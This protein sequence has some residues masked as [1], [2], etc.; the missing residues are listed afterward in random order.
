V[1]LLRRA[2]LVPGLALALLASATGRAPAAAED[3]GCGTMAIPLREDASVYDLPHTFVRAGTDS[4]WTRSGPLRRGTDYV[5]DR[6]RGQLRLIARVPAGDTLW[7]SAC[8]LLS[9]LPLS[10]QLFHYRA[11]ALAAPDTTRAAGPAFPL[12]PATRRDPRDAPAG[13]SLNV[14]GNKTIAI[15][16]GSSQDAFLRQSLDLAVSGSLAPGVSLTGVLSDRNTPLSEAGSTQDLQSLD[17][18]LVE[19]KTPQGGAALGDVTLSLPQGD[20]ARL[21]RRLQGARGEWSSRGFQGV[22]AAASAQGEYHRIQFFGIEG[23]QGPYALTDRDGNPGIAVV[24]GSEVVTVDGSRMTRGE[25]ADY[26]MDYERGELTFSNR[27]PVSSASRITVEYQFAVNRYRRNLAAADAEWRLGSAR[28]FTRML[29]EGDDRGRP[30]E[31][32]FD[33]TDRLVLELAGDSLTRAIG[34]GV[35]AGGGDY[36]TVRVAAGQVFAFAGPDAGTF[37]V[38]FARVGAGEGDY[39]D[40]A[41]VAG[42]TAYRFVGA[43]RGAYRVG[44]ALPLPES[45]QL[46]AV[47]GGVTLGPLTL[48]TEGAVSRHDLNTF[49]RLDD[50]DNTGQ[51]GRVALAL[52][53]GGPGPLGRVGVAL[54]ARAVEPRFEPFTRLERPFAQEDWGL[55]PGADLE[56][57]RRLEA[58]GF[59]K[60][61]FGG[62][63][64]ATLARLA[65]PDGF[66]S[67]RRGL[68]WNRDGTLATQASAE[69]SDARDGRRRFADGG[70]ERW[71]GELRLRT[72]WLEPALRAESD[73][74][75]VPSDSARAGARSREVGLELPSARR[76]AWHAVA[77]YV[78]RRDGTLGPRDFEDLTEART[79]R[80]GLDGPSTGLVG[81]GLA[82]QRRELEPLAGTV[83]TRSD[84]A[85]MRLRLDDPKRGVSGT[86]NLEVTAEGEGRRVRTLSFVGAGRG[87]YDA[88]GN[89]VGTGDYTLGVGVS[90]VLDRVARAAL[91]AR[92]A[93]QFGASD[94]WR[95]S[96]LEFDFESDAR[97][98]GDL[99][100]AD[101]VVSP[102]SVL[103]D[104][105]LSRGSVL[106]RLEA[107][108]AP[109]SHAAAM[110]LLAERRVS[111]DRAFE[112]FGQTTDDRSLSL[113]WRARPG[114]AVTSELESR[115]RRQEA[116]QTLLGLP[117]YRRVL[118]DG[119]GA[120]QLTMTPD[121]RVRLV[122]TVDAAWARPEGQAEYTRTVKLGPDV[123]LA[124]GARGRAELGARRY[125][126]AGPALVPLLPSAE[127]L[128]APRWDANTRFDY[129]VRESTTLGLSVT[130][131]DVPGAATRYTGRAEVRA[132]F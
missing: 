100:A 4:A 59:V 54:A 83:R 76:F 23:R 42:R 62:Q 37:A 66:T 84:L 108:L 55:A 30:L 17:R 5:L 88:Y 56:H 34:A 61:R 65:L 50:G 81:L 51:A 85:T 130:A 128:A 79:L 29:T 125:L 102:G 97:R 101:L 89:F 72:A 90:A 10:L 120:A 40:S 26:A 58:S 124:V 12:R 107:E 118:I 28:A 93:W 15:D 123:G 6:L 78:L 24:A 114:S 33:A 39:A 8:W 18:V 38:R 71:R 35:A 25:S 60:P 127:P 43:G 46:W 70:R 126:V 19:L 98:R 95:G 122:G 14:T 21:E 11:L 92:I 41:S 57:Q 13:A 22:V 99:R 9:P 47:G 117:P 16:F 91:S 121:A 119:G 20:F 52:E 48:E 73:E 110:R 109:G 82:F 111:A 7:V 112:N 106:Q 49:S 94:A 53:G 86:A 132:F 36:D 75:R 3:P 74:R 116:G 96:R 1:A 63:L 104:G 103:G 67:L 44:R 32:T 87:Q 77:G 64:R 105:A 80:L 45:H 113:R 115:L 131:R 68:E 31:L 27:R 2:G 69:R 129:R